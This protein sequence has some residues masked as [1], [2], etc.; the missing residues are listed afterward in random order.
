MP[1]TVRAATLADLDV[2][3][4]NCL[5]VARESEGLEPDPVQA[6]AAAEAALTDPRKA[7]YFVAEDTDSGAVVGSL[8][9]T[10]EWSD[11]KNGWYW[12]MQGVFVQ[13]DRRG[14][15]IYSRM[16]EAVHAAAR[17]AGDVRSIRLYV[18]EGNEAG[19]RA[20]RGHGMTETRYRIFEAI[21]SQ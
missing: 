19:L 7:R 18:D 3:V 10:F 17:A 8:F 16:Y 9:V 4:S 2:L 15:G 5:G 13:P 11:W 12:W 14:E 21:V 1:V 20:Y 6:R